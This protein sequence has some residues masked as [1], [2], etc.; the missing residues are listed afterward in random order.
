MS[1]V[2]AGTACRCF[3]AREAARPA[4]LPMVPPDPAPADPG[5]GLGMGGAG[6][7]RDR[8]SA[9]GSARQLSRNGTSAQ[10]KAAADLAV[11]PVAKQFN[12]R[13]ESLPNRTQYPPDVIA[14]VV[15]WGRANSPCAT[16]RR[17]S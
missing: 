2:G 17:S 1:R 14:L 15:L 7:E 3:C 6:E 12:E 4:A 10:L 11:A 16:Y 13:S 5:N 8:R 9:L